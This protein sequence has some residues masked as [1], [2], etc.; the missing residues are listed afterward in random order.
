MRGPDRRKVRTER[1][2]RQQATDA[3]TVLWFALRGRRRAGLKFVRQE[4]IGRYVADFVCREAKLVI[5][6]D[7]GQHADNPRDAARDAW[8]AS[9]GYRVLRN[10]DVLSSKDSV[11][12][13]IL[14][15]LKG[16]VR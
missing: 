1:R 9:E 12:E 6:V 3:E 2:P 15:V 16:D 13:T 4:A 5:E 8:L 11:L 14:S 10:S 7:G